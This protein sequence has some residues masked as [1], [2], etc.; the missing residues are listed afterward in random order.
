MSMSPTEFTLVRH[1][2]TAWNAEGRMQ[3]HLDVPLNEQGRRQAAALGTR[4]ARER[5]D[6][7]YS[8]DLSRALQTA[9]SLHDSGVAVIRE[10]RLRE[11]HYGTLQGLTAAEAQRQH[12]ELWQRYKARDPELVLAGGETL[13]QF[14]ARVTTLIEELN[15]RHR[16]Q[17][18]LL[19]THG[20]VLDAA[21]RHA[22]DMPL[23]LTRTF[24]VRNASLNV[25]ERK[26]RTWHIASWG[27]V[28][29]LKAEALDGSWM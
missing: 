26:E 8:S 28:E 2:E 24:S 22:T 11:R 6:A 13:R 21:Y 18:V 25:I 5:F 19:V 23:H 1:G 16:G 10:P 17:R 20:G 7:V 9:A 29:H 27:D 12:A 4:L 14:A 15:T 3:G